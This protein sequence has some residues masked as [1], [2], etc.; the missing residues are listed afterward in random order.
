MPIA[1]DQVAEQSLSQELIDTIVIERRFCGPPD[2]GNGGYVC[3]RLAH[4][5]AGPAT[6]RLMKP[7]PLDIPLDVMN[8][9]DEIHLKHGSDT[10]ARAWAGKPSI[11][12]PAAPDLESARR[13]RNN[14]AGHAYH[15][16]P[17][18]FVCGTHRQEGDGLLIYSGPPEG[19][20]PVNDLAEH[21]VACT[22][23]PHASFCGDDGGLLPHYYWAA[24]DCPGA[25][26]FLSFDDDVALL[27]EFSV[28]T[29]LK[30]ECGRE[31]IVAG[32]E[33]SREGRKR[34]TGSAI[35]DESG[36]PVAW[37]QATWIIIESSGI[38]LSGQ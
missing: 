20:G 23:I 5:F 24:L 9:A 15:M 26:S 27:G 8:V 21:H 12:V 37:A 25:W 38:S 3:G 36:T 30:I 22:W 4:Y 34:L 32:W 11:E 2:S 18:C 10:I 31:Y 28:E 1:N 7:P 14:Y 19:L 33:V 17:G 29:V 13:R 35:Y 6:V 16:F